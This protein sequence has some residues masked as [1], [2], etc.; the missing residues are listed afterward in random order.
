MDDT[1]KSLAGSASR[2]RFLAGVA[3]AAGAAGAF[4]LVVGLFG[5]QAQSL[6][7]VA[8]RPPGALSEKKFLSACVRCGLCVRD[9]PYP[10]LSLAGVGEDVPVGTPYFIA[11]RYPCEMC[12]DVPCVKACPTGAL[13]PELNT[14]DDARMGLAVLVDEE[15]CLNFLG[16]RCDVCYRVCPVIDKAITL[17]MSHN[18]RTRKHA[19][20]IPTVH[21]DSCTGCGKC[22]RACVL[23][24]A[25]IRVFPRH[26]AKGRIGEHYRLGWVEKEK[27]GG[28]SLAPGMVDLPD[29]L[30][31]E[32]P[33]ALKGWKP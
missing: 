18:T 7:A 14:I 32:L 4:G 33:D 30:P 9:C 6:P 5:R 12:D 2:R 25:A 15:T 26:L 10:T 31:D 23:D 21:S 11:R 22:E 8:I 3:R 16:L 17:E 29:R 13:D 19:V 1:V 28:E 24:T 27:H 20:F